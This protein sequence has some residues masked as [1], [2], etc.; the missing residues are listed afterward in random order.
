MAVTPL[1]FHGLVFL[2][3]LENAPLSQSN[4]TFVASGDRT[5]SLIFSGENGFGRFVKWYTKKPNGSIGSYFGGNI[6]NEF[7][8]FFKRVQFDGYSGGFAMY[9][10]DGQ[11]HLVGWSRAYEVTLYDWTFIDNRPVNRTMY[12]VVPAL[13]GDYGRGAWDGKD[14]VYFF[15]ANSLS[16]YAWDIKNPTVAVK[17]IVKLAITREIENLLRGAWTGTGMLVRDGVIFLPSSA[18]EDYASDIALLAYDFNTGEHLGNLLSSE[19]KAKGFNMYNNNKGC[20]QLHP[21]YDLAYYMPYSK[22]RFMIQY[23][24]LFLKLIG[25]VNYTNNIHNQNVNMT[26]DFVKQPD[27][28]GLGDQARFR[29]FV[30]GIK[31]YPTDSDFTDIQPTPYIATVNGL[32]N[33]FFNKIGENKVT[34]EAENG[35]GV[36]VSKDVYVN[37]VN[38]DPVITKSEASPSTTHSDLV[39]VE[40]TAETEAGDY[41]SYRVTLNEKVHAD[42]SDAIYTTPLHIR[43]MLKPSD[44]KIGKNT[45]KIEVKDNFKDNTNVSE[46]TIT[47]VKTNTK[48]NVELSVKGQ[49]VFV[50]ATDNDND[51][52]RFNVSINGNSFLPVSGMSPYYEVPFETSVDIPKQMIKLVQENTVSVS[53][54]DAAGDIVKQEVTSSIEM[55]GLMFR[56]KNGSYYTTDT[57]ELLKYLDVGSLKS[58]ETSPAYQV[59]IE[60]TTGYLMHGVAVTAIQGD[61]DPITEKIELSKENSPFTSVEYVA[62]PE[63][64]QPKQTES[65]FFR[66]VCNNDA[67]GGGVFKLKVYG[68]PSLTNL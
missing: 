4:A 65:F 38:T 28:G 10:K 51:K 21:T 54:Q 50:S 32:S 62:F 37:V 61:L 11:D 3:N 53:V 26:I 12:R 25:D 66:I 9:T 27:S 35:Q 42:W 60:N 19:L 63:P 58:G 64:L 36:I 41:M 48:P 14:T 15:D 34:I 18:S 47:V 44:L 7:D 56:D 17:Y 39:W 33:S 52:V 43:F 20:I 13:G 8:T 5:E 45:I 40:A 29:I 2:D 30:N 31:I 6:W 57:G 49:T 1:S 22:Q 68:K 46:S 67:A 55:S 59:W 23:S 24:T 16:L